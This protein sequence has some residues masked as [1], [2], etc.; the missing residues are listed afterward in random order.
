M[1]Q[2]SNSPSKAEGPSPDPPN[3]RLVAPSPDIP[4][5]S[6]QVPPQVPL[7]GFFSYVNVSASDPFWSPQVT[8]HPSGQNQTDLVF[9]TERKE[10]TEH[11]LL[12]V[13]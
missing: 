9:C 13:L 7:S 4:P 1:R 10:A 5:K 11:L 6:R 8:L 12:I 2:V 3:F